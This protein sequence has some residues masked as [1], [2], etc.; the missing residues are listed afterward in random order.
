MISISDTAQ[1]HFR[2]LLEKQPDGTNIRVFVVNPG[3]Q[4]AECGVSYCP[5]DAVDP[6][7]QHLPFSGF[8]CLVDPLS[9]PFLVDATIDFVTNQMG[10]QLTLKAPNAKMRKVADDAPLIDRIEYVLMSEVNPMLAGH[11]GKVTL[12]ELTDD[13]LAILQFGGGC[14]GC[15]M[16][17]YTLKEGIEKQ[18]LEKF[19]GELN[20]V[21][22]ATEHQRGDHSYY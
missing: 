16:V 22:D 13:K 6:E 2:K 4:N 9:A 7:D 12:V 11:G 19:P 14:N 15:S 20:G 10:S 21:K 18:L 5:P 1:A 8:D 3:T 17:D